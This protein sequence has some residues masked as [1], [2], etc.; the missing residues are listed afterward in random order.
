MTRTSAPGD[1]SSPMIG[2][3][4]TH[5]SS[6]SS[7]SSS[8]TV[9]KETKYSQ[10]PQKSLEMRVV[11][12]CKQIFL[13]TFAE[14]KEKIEDDW[15]KKYTLETHVI[16]YLQKLLLQMSI[17]T[18][19][20]NQ[21]EPWTHSQ[22][23]KMIALWKCAKRLDVRKYFKKLAAR[24][25]LLDQKAEAF[26]AASQ[27]N[28]ETTPESTDPYLSAMPQ[29][30]EYIIPK[31]DD[32]EDLAIYDELLCGNS[33]KLKGVT[34]LTIDLKATPDDKDDKI[35]HALYDGVEKDNF[36]KMRKATNVPSPVLPFLV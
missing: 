17:A 4:P 6:S 10:A 22:C 1:T 2:V 20:L 34:I 19:V 23:V 26:P 18:T 14:E 27:P 11:E 33:Y 8:S 31:Y 30:I 36:S 13:D 21:S 16:E 9:D 28:I 12:N 15:L 32:K 3:T 35:T 24:K 29:A 25:G 5:T 7:S